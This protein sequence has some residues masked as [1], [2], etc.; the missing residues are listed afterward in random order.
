MKTSKQ[1]ETKSM[2]IRPSL[3]DLV[4]HRILT[5]LLPTKAAVRM[6]FLSKQWEGVWSLNPVLDFDESAKVHDDDIVFD[7]LVDQHKNFINIL[8]RYLEFCEKGE[9]TQVLDRFRL[10]M[11]RYLD[12]D[13]SIVDKWLDFAYERSVKEVDLSLEIGWHKLPKRLEDIYCISP[14]SFFL[15]KSLTTLNLESVRLQNTYSAE[16]GHARVILPCLKNM[17]LKGVYLDSQALN[18]L[19][20]GCPSIECLSLTS[21]RCFGDWKIIS[22]SSSSLKSLK[23][24][25]CDARSIG[26]YEVVNLEHFTILSELRLENVT[27]ERSVNL[28]CVIIHARSLEQFSLF[29][30][31]DSVEATINAP[32]LL[33]FRFTCFL[34]SKLYLK[35]PTLQTCV[36]HLQDNYNGKSHNFP[37]LRDFLEVFDGTDNLIIYINDFKVITFPERFRETYLSPLPRINRLQVR[38]PD[39]PTEEKDISDLDDSLT[40]VVQSKCFDW[41]NQIPFYLKA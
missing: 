36:I 24:T 9:T 3:P 15:A 13:F 17:S 12:S 29:A 33:D 40:W 41:R 30:S 11:T 18:G 1:D 37:A 28:K 25:H 32:G 27:L 22:F 38:M 14:R 35:D 7:K 23:V 2:T 34:K 19:I 26:V 20:L 21:C 4:I 5:Q 6:S 39:T 31:H 16:L 10:H 8:L